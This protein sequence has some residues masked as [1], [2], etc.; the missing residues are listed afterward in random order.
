MLKN[1][2][3]SHC[4][5]GLAIFINPFISCDRFR[6]LTVKREVL[7]SSLF[8]EHQKASHKA[9]SWMQ[10]FAIFIKSILNFC[11]LMLSAGVSSFRPSPAMVWLHLLNLD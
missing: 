11:A 5:T 1:A 2:C 8:Q 4:Y 6:G 7:L 3:L 9:Y 10:F